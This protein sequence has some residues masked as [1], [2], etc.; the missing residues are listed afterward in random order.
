VVN[1]INDKEIYAF[2]SGGANICLA[3]GSVR[4]LKQTATMDLVLSLL[5]RNRG[6]IVPS[7][8]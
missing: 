4:F 6:E 3:D 8:F 2:H 1:C 7:D 5:T